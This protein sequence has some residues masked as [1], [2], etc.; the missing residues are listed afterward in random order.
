MGENMPRLLSLSLATFLAAA[1]PALGGE[2]PFAAPPP[3]IPGQPN[4]YV[5]PLADIMGRI[6]LRH[7]KLW[8]AIK[9]RNWDLLDF[10]L[11]LTKDSFGNAVILYR[12]IPVEFIVAAGKPLAEM[13]KAAKAKDSSQLERSYAELTAACNACHKAADVGFIV[14]KTPASS[15]FGDQ[16][17]SPK[18]K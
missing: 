17:F 8:E 7:M 4:T 6:Q 18:E 3:S 2:V 15:P 1:A 16:E 10:E 11:E 9:H 14:I 13:Q 12:N 5:A